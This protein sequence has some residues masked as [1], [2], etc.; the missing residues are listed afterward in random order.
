MSASTRVPQSVGDATNLAEFLTKIDAM[1]RVA[2]QGDFPIPLFRGQEDESWLLKPGIAREQYTKGV[3]PDTEAR[4]LAEF[5][6]RGIPHLESAVPL[7]DAD[8]LAI[9]QHHGMPTRL[10]DW[11]GSALTALWFAIQRPAVKGGDGQPKAAAVWMLA[12]SERDFITDE[13]R[14]K[15]LQLG[16]TKLLKPRHVSRRIA[17]QDGWFTVHRGTESGEGVHYASVDTNL[18]YDFRVE[19]VRIPPKAFG[20]LRAQLQ[21]AGINRGVLFPDLGGVA[22]RITDAILPPGDQDEDQVEAEIL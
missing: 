7:A 8:W 12:A 5:K 10:L 1:V 4:M 17:A 6:H 22:G 19:Y 14:D 20:P 15:P 21:L 16:R 11:T 18:T 2:R 9:A 3:R 13:E